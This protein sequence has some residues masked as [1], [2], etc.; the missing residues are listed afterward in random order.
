LIENKRLEHLPKIIQKYIDY[1]RIL[2]KE[3]DITIISAND[4]NE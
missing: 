2:N 1:Y 4:L 3:E